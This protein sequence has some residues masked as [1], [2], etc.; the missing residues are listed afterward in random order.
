MD[1]MLRLGMKLRPIVTLSH[2]AFFLDFLSEP[3]AC[4]THASAI[5]TGTFLNSPKTLTGWAWLGYPK[6][7]DGAM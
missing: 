3:K 7:E 6:K 4:T 5:L 2:L 1:K